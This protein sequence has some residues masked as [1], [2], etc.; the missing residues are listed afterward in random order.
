MTGCYSDEPLYCASVIWQSPE[1]PVATLRIP[2]QDFDNEER[3]RMAR[4][5][6]INPWH[7]IAEHRPLGNQNRARRTIYYETSRVRQRINAE[8]HRVPD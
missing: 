5:L 7:T 6:T 1:I 2:P 3:D 8:R 4:E